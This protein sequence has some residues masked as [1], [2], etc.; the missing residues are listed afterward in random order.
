[1]I[2]FDY[3]QTLGD[4]GFCGIKGTE[5]VLQYATENKYHLTPQQV[6]AKAE[7]INEE[8]GRF[9][10]IKKY[11]MQTE[12]PNYMFTSYLY[13]SLG[14][15]LSLSSKEIDQVFWDAAAPAVPT[16]GIEEFLD[17][18]HQQGIRTGVISNITYD[19]EVVK[20]RIDTL[21][22]NHHFEFIIAT[23]GYLFRKPNK[24]IFL[25][26]LEKAQLEAGDVWYIGDQYEA[27]VVGA[28][29]AGI[30]PV[31]YQGASG[32]S[33]SPSERVLTINHWKEL[34]EEIENS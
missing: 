15:Q 24:R 11:Q 32:K 26:A 12:I 22:P 33:F 21:L 8:L 10:P 28:E 7:A 17:F 6:Q 4:E 18:L 5:A 1:M 2:L 14:I 34:R 19:V 13:E 27:D 31:W 23:S 25:L 20:N 30:F 16:E 29:G 3:G 9:D